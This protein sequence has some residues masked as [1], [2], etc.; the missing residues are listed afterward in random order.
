GGMITLKAIGVYAGRDDLLNGARAGEGDSLGLHHQGGGTADDL[1]SNSRSV[2]YGSTGGARGACCQANDE[3]GASWKTRTTLQMPDFGFRIL[4]FDSPAA[5][6]DS[7][8]GHGQVG[9]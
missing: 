3:N 8:V 7:K 5:G 9:G 1:R 4:H 6:A 2:W